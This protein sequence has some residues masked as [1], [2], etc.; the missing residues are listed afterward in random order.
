MSIDLL[1]SLII[2]LSASILAGT[3]AAYFFL[4]YWEVQVSKMSF[5]L[6]HERWTRSSP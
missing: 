5:D 3:L 4:R 2:S 1:T 6:P